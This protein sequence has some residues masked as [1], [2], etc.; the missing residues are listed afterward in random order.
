MARKIGMWEGC[1]RGCKV[2]PYGIEHGYLD[3]RTLAEMV[4]D[5]VLCNGII[6]NTWE[7]CGEWEVWSGTDYDEETDSYAEVYQEFI[8]S[9]FGADV[10]HRFTD[11]LV[12]YNEELDLNVW[13]ITHFGTSWDYVLT[14]VELVECDT[15][16]ELIAVN[17]RSES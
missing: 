5:M 17:E 3:Y 6:R 14:D 11:E 9:N 16:E 15:L 13:C 8:V 1:V 2:S 12:Y 4:E 7:S 10:L